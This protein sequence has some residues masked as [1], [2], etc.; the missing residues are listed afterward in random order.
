[1][2]SVYRRKV[3]SFF[4]RAGVEVGGD[5][6]ADIRVTDERFFQRVARQGTLGL[7][8]SY[9]DGWWECDALDDL[10]CKLTLVPKRRTRSWARYVHKLRSKLLNLQTRR[11]S[12]DVVDQHY[13]LPDVLYER[14]L[15]P[16]MQYSCGWWRGAD[17]LPEAQRGKMDLICR[18]LDLQPG[19]RV[20]D[21]GGGWGGL[22]RH[23]AETRGCRV[24]AVNISRQQNAYAERVN[25]GLPVEVVQA[26]YR[27]LEGTWDKVVSV[28][29]FEHV[30]RRNY[31]EW[32]QTVH[33]A[34]APGGVLLLHTIG[35]NL[36]R[37][38]ADRWI[39]RHI[40]PGGH[41]P[42]IRA[43]GEASEKLFVMEDWHNLGQDYD[44]TLM[45]WYGNFRA[46]W[47]ELASV[48]QPFSDRFFRM[49]SYYLLMSAG[50]FRGRNIQLWQIVF[51][52]HRSGTRYV[53]PRYRAPGPRE[54]LPGIREQLLSGGLHLVGGRDPI[55]PAARQ[56]EVEKLAQAGR[57]LG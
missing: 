23:M 22:A 30:G 41:L 44:P 15:D 55:G 20:L 14:M 9:T 6:S 12:R 8:D 46:A 5:G 43:I 19:D 38:Y 3:T 51:T 16:A 4:A 36:E 26:D 57:E 54:A 35:D 37:P 28:G 50:S 29:M 45:A 48:G 18:K 42:S 11:R 53:V 49:W 39:L 56:Q 13:E 10:F 17:T 52:R 33:R 31:R 40:F 2:D 47:D 1:M 34:L 24:T 21:I 27:D 25:Q 32:F 7:G